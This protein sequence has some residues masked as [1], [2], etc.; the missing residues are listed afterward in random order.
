MT[1]C[2]MGRG[3]CIL[4]I[5]ST[6][7]GIFLIKLW[8]SVPSFNIII[9]IPIYLKFEAS[10][11]AQITVTYITY[12]FIFPYMMWNWNLNWRYSLI[13]EIGQCFR[14]LSPLIFSKKCIVIYKLWSVFLPNL[15]RLNVNF[16][17]CA[18]VDISS[19]KLIT[20]KRFQEKSC[21]HNHHDIHTPH[22][23]RGILNASFQLIPCRKICK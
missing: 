1:M 13:S 12:F 11:H 3:I 2:D 4:F 14:Q 20:R 16:I 22:L 7:L 5:T 10:S 19:K 18:E 9:L 21:D 6:R 15:L 8:S 17:A 23:S